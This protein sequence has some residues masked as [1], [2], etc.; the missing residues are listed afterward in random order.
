MDWGKYKLELCT[1]PAVI[2]HLSEIARLRITIFE[3]Y[4]YLYKG[5]REIETKYL[6]AYADTPDACVFVVRDGDAIIGAGTGVP[7]HG[8]PATFT[9]PFAGSPFSL[10]TIYYLGEVLFLPGYRGQGL[11]SR[12]LKEFEEH[13]RSLGRYRHLACATIERPEDHPLR[14]GDYHPID[15]YLIKAGFIRHPELS[16]TLP[17]PNLEGEVTDNTMVF[18]VKELE[19]L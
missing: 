17:W 9:A 5:S 7:L 3:E 16:V 4:P 8:E 2:P 6:R 11:G 10:D 19:H 18:W 13:I 1:G 12:L 15:G 14:P